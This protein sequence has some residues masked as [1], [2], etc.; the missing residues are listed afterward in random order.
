VFVPAAA[1]ETGGSQWKNG[2]LVHEMVHALDLAAGHYD[3]NE[4]VRERR[5]V[6]MQ[7]IWRTHTGAELRTSYHDRFATLDF[8]NATKSNTV[9]KY[10]GYIFSRSDLPPPVR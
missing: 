1:V 9:P 4:P 6:F 2:V 7:N 10:L 5:A 3:Q 8:Q